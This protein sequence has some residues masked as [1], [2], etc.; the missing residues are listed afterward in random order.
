MVLSTYYLTF[1]FTY[2]LYIIKTFDDAIIINTK[3]EGATQTV[4]KGAYALQ[5]TLMFLLFKQLP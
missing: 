4:G 2:M 3:E 1:R 5:P